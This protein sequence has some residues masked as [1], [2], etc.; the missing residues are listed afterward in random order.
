MHVDGR[1]I[2]VARI[3]DE[4][5]PVAVIEAFFPSPDTLRQAAQ[6]TP[7]SEGLNR[8]PGIRAPLPDGYWSESQIRLCRAIIAQVFNLSGT[9]T[10]LDS[11]FSMVTTPAASLS[12]DQRIPHADAFSARHVA[13]VHYLALGHCG[14][15][16]FYRHRSTGL[17]TISAHNRSRYFDAVQAELARDGPPPACYIQGDTDL[18]EQIY[19]VE[20]RFNRAVLYRG[21]Q[22]HSGVIPPAMPLLPDPA[23]ARLTIT[24]FM[25]IG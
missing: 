6:A 20:G 22:L 19:A 16:A 13:L 2:C 9:L 5:Q 11:S 24:A 7:F 14:G 18:F 8:Y 1:E 15:T 21:Q 12:P 4:G 10:L 23:T 25:T 17:Q 3:G